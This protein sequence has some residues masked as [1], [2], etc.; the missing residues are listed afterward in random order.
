MEKNPNKTFPVTEI[1]L[2]SGAKESNTAAELFKNLHDLQN[3]RHKASIL[4]KNSVMIMPTA[5]GKFHKR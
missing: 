2:R 5:G 3:Y 1:I 4:L